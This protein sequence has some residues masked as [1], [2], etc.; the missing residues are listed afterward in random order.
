MDE[1]NYTTENNVEPQNKNNSFATASMVTGLLGFLSVF[2]CC[3][4]MGL[5]LGISSIV[6][7]ILSK[8]RKPFHGLAIAGLILGILSIITSILIFAYFILVFALMKDPQYGPMLNDLFR[9]YEDIF[10]YIPK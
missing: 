2:C 3:F 1:Y 5:I 7:A 8:Q 9:E 10:N 4:P 6:L